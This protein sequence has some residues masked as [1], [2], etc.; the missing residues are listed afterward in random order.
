MDSLTLDCSA[1]TVLSAMSYVMLAAC[2]QNSLLLTTC[3]THFSFLDNSLVF[4]SEM[5]SHAA[6]P[7]ILASAGYRL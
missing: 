4:S 6:L 5:G 7:Y 2:A 3:W 1:V